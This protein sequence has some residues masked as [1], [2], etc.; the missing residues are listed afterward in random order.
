MHQRGLHAYLFSH[1]HLNVYL[2]ISCYYA[3]IKQRSASI[4]YNIIFIKGKLNRFDYMYDN[5]KKSTRVTIVIVLTERCT[6][7]NNNDE[8]YKNLDVV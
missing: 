7:M 8:K 5:L 4:S 3:T 2:E 1:Q 6:Q